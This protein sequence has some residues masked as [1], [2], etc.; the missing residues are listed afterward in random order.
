MIA[1][2]PAAAP[3]RPPGFTQVAV[4]PHGGV[5]LSGVFPDRS[6]PQP[7]RRGYLYLPPGLAAGTRY[8]V[9][10][11]LHGMPGDPDEYVDSLRL[12]DVADTLIS[13]GA[14]KPFVA[15]LPAAGSS[16]HYDGEWAGP[17]ETYL[18]DGVVPWVDA[19]L[20]TIATASG[21]TLAGLSAGGYGAIDI[22]LRNPQLFGRLESWS[23]YF[24]PLHDGPFE[25]ADGA[26]LRANDPVAIVRGSAALVRALGIRFF[27]G[28]GPSHSHWFKAQETL[29]FASLLQRL[30][31]PETLRVLSSAKGQ[32]GLQL[33]AGL[34]WALG[35]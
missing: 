4:G 32:Y 25:H 1:A 14:V 34:R 23:G 17:W 27:L 7:L 12:A 30:R 5:L 29:D 18:V 2:A 3:P 19:H 31:L 21:R 16:P 10:Y 26:T 6:A 33:D 11:L 9:V 20:P 8:P 22:G 35:S 15:V 28:T 13:G 24:H